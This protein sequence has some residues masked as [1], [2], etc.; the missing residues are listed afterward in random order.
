MCHPL[1]V[2]RL[3]VFVAACAFFALPALAQQEDGQVAGTVR[4]AT[5][6]ATPG[7][8]VTVVDRKGQKRVATS[9][10]DGAYSVTGVP[11]V[12]TRPSHYRVS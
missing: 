5:G 3:H 1:A 10:G 7:A 9:G 11:G 4:D 8:T 2:S 12:Y 6:A